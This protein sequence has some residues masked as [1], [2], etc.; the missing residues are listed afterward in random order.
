[1]DQIQKEIHK[2]EFEEK[3]FTVFRNVIDQDLLKE[4]NDHLNFLGRKYPHLRP[5]H[6]HHPLIRDD[7]FW[8]RFVTDE[9]LLD[10]AECF[11]GPDLANFTAHYISK[12][13]HDGQS[14]LWH[15]DGAYWNL[16]PMEAVSLW[17]AI[18]ETTPENGCLQMIPGTHKLSLQKL[19]LRDDLP[20]MLYSSVDYEFDTTQAVN[21]LLQPGDVSVHNP[22]I[23][24]G[25]NANK[26]AQRRCG[27]DMGFIKTSTAVQNKG[28]YLYPLLVRGDAVPGIN[29]YRPWPSFDPEKTI[30]FRGW[31]HWNERIGEKNQGLLKDESE[32]DVIGVVNHMIDR[33]KEGTT[34]H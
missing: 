26:T 29:T 7:A 9:R 22:F 24:H 5:E 6:Y 23:I 1:M 2:K 16:H 33:L 4:A 25:S 3:G 14:V 32:E 10:I 12:P 17:C 28:L 21:I 11:L 19:R 18:D 27:L 20:N 8:V 34:A 15:Q 31:K 30:Y 13:S